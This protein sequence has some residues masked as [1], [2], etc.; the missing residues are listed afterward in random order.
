VEG[1]ADKVMSQHYIIAY[2]DQTQ[3]LTDLCRLLG[4]KILS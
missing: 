4:I 3:V 1:F 2:G